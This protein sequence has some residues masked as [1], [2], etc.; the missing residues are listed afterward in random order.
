MAKA[1]EES[2]SDSD[3]GSDSDSDWRMNDQLNLI[4]TLLLFDEAHAHGNIF[5][6]Q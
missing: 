6:S 4:N 5:K 3:S 1:E 2:D